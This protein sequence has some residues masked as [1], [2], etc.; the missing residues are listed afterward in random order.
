[1]AITK[2]LPPN[3]QNIVKPRKAS[4]ETRRWLVAGRG[5]LV[6]SA[7]DIAAVEVDIL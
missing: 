1:M 2:A 3:S 5:G 7:T 4:S 6:T